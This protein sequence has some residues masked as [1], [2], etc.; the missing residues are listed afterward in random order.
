MR[1]VEQTSLEAFYLI[2][3]ELGKRQLEVLAALRKIGE[4]SYS[5]IARASGLPINCVIPRITEL[6][7]MKVVDSRG[8]DYCRCTGRKVIFWRVA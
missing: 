4:G 2:K 5:M 8:Y 1:Q 3:H 7:Q 6:K